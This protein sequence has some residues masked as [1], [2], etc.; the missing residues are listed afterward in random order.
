MEER[1]M[2]GTKFAFYIV[3]SVR[4]ESRVLSTLFLIKMRKLKMDSESIKIDDIT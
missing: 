3:W 1:P 4:G 2:L